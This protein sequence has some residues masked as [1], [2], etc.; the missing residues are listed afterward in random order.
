VRRP[1]LDLLRYRGRKTNAVLLKDVHGPAVIRDEADP[2]PSPRYKLVAG[3]GPTHCVK[4]MFGAD[5]CAWHELSSD[6]QIPYAP[7]SGL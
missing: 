1:A 4:V 7:D 6:P 3:L 5:G 2:E